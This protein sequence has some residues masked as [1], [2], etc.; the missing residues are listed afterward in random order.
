MDAFGPQREAG[1]RRHLTRFVAVG[2]VGVAIQLFAIHLYARVFELHYLVAT[3]AAVE[4]A[5]LHNF[6]WHRCWTWVDRA[7]GGMSEAARMLL[8]YNLT[9]GLVSATG[10]VVA[11]YALVGGARLPVIVANL[12]T[13]GACSAANYVL[14]DRIVFPSRGASAVAS[15]RR[16]RPDRPQRVDCVLSHEGF[17]VVDDSAA[18]RDRCT[19]DPDEAERSRRAGAHD[20]VLV[21]KEEPA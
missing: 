2:I 16:G 6:V 9:T 13:I 18:Q 19:I 20:C 12:I 1:T 4:T 14:A 10:N 7:E 21:P 8:R 3:V 5:T 11:M 15:G 17:D